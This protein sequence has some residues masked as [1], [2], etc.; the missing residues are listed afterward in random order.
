MKSI[1]SVVATLKV[2]KTEASKIRRKS[3]KQLQIA[4]SLYRRSKSGLTSTDK[5]IGK[6]QEELFDVTSV[7]TQKLAQKES[8]SRLVESAEQKLALEQDAKIQAEQDLEYA[9]DDTEKTNIEKRLRGISERISDIQYELKSRQKLFKKLDGEISELIVTKDKI[10]NKIDKATKTK[11][12]LK[13]LLK[14]SQKDSKALSEQLEQSAKKEENAKKNLQK[15][16][17]KLKISLRKKQ[18][19]SGKKTAKSKRTA[20]TG[21][22]PKKTAKSKRTATTGSKPKK[23]AKSKRTATTGS[24]PKKTAKS[25]RTATTGSKPKKTAKSKRTATTGSKPK[26]TAKS[27]TKN[28]LKPI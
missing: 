22:K 15:A 7:L 5:K 23:T 2:K 27:K 16:E 3:E 24:K 6:S 10:T 14:N 4:K 19:I 11:P 17:E 9:S 28:V 25:K 26:K 13:K 1:Q 21:S 18:K 12:E 20:T 8:I